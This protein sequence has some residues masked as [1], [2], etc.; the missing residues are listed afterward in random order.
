MRLGKDKLHFS[1]AAKGIK[2]QSMTNYPAMS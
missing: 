2:K 1:G